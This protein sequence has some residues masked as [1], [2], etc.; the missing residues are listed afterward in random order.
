MFAAN[1]LCSEWKIEWTA[2]NAMFS[3]PRPSPV[4]K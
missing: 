1:R 4:M 2:V 3:L